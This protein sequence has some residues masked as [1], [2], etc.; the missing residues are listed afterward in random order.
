VFATDTYSQAVQGYIDGVQALFAGPAGA[1]AVERGARGPAS[2]ADLAQRAEQLAPRSEALTQAAAGRLSA[3][4]PLERMQAETALLAKA[5]ADL[6]VSA[7]L[8]QAAQDEEDEITWRAQ[9]GTERGATAWSALDEPLKYLLGEIPLD[10]QASERGAPA[11]QDVPT[12][13]AALSRSIGDALDLISVLAAETGQ[14]AFGGLLG[15]GLAE[16]VQAAGVVGMDIATALGQ[17]EK[18]TRLYNLFREFVLKAYG[19]VMA[20]L[21]KQL[22]QLAADRVVAWM[23]DLQEG[24]HVADL[25]ETLYQ[26]KQTG[27]ELEQLVLNSPVPLERF[28]ASIE[29]VQGLGAAYRQQIALSGKLLKGLRLF[30]G[31]P[32]AALPQGKLLLAAA[33]ILLGGYVVMAGADF[34]DAQRLA[35]FDRVAGVRSTVEGNLAEA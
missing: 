22:A 4:E 16:V 6:Q 34:V 1:Q 35:W 23:N 24:K 8:L 25:L 17:A 26:T 5:L 32:G 13:R 27:Q 11:P 7:Y 10:I 29:G 31:V 33:N 18:V 3:A 2:Y 15:L 9:A 12:A 14:T 30:A 28:V 19:S 21:G 20:L